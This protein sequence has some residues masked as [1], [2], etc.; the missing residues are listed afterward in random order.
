MVALFQALW[1]WLKRDAD[2]PLPN[3]K[4]AFEEVGGFEEIEEIPSGD[5]EL[6]MMKLSQAYPNAVVFR[7]SEAAMVSTPAMPGWSELRQQHQVESGQ[8]IGDPSHSTVCF[9]TQFVLVAIAPFQ[10]SPLGRPGNAYLGLRYPFCGRGRL[11]YLP[12]RLFSPSSVL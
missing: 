7:K 3:V 5:D 10:F 4:S 6:L 11:D 9:C 1:V 8:E 12:E 2:P